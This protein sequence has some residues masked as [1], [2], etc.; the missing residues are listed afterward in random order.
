MKTKLLVESV[1]KGPQCLTRLT[2]ARPLELLDH[3]RRTLPTF[4]PNWHHSKRHER[5]RRCLPR[6]SSLWH[7]CVHPYERRSSHFQIWRLQCK[8]LGSTTCRRNGL[9]LATSG[10]EQVLLMPDNSP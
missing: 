1:L 3:H 2:C 7:N 9:A 6:S 4:H 8:L 10:E 5:H